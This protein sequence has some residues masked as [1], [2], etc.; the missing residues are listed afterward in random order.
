VVTLVH[1]LPDDQAP[2]ER[3]ERRGHIPTSQTAPRIDGNTS[4][5]TLGT[6]SPDESTRT[7]PSVVRPL[8]RLETLELSLRVVHDLLRT[9]LEEGER[10]Q[11]AVLA[12]LNRVRTLLGLR[13]IGD[14]EPEHDEGDAPDVLD[15]NQL[16]PTRRPA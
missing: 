14:V 13:L 7:P 6:R 12:S 16:S 11:S 5:S 2:N 4:D 15:M 9:L 1:F 10:H 3:E 8:Q